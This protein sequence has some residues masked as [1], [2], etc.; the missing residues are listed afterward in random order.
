MSK[1]QGHDPVRE[2]V[3]RQMR[4]RRVAEHDQRRAEAEV[5]KLERWGIDPPYRRD[6]TGY[7]LAALLSVG[8]VWALVTGHVVVQGNVGALGAYAR[9]SVQW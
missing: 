9:V 3:E 8:L 6:W 5:N 4:G 2:R 1:E 7:A